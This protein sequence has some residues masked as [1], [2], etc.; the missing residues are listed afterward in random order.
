VLTLGEVHTG[1]LLTSSAVTNDTASTLLAV[2]PGGAVRSRRRPVR[3]ACSP[4]VLTGVDCPARAPG[5]RAARV[6]GTATSRVSLTDGHILQVGTHASLVRDPGGRRRPWAHYLAQ[7]GILEVIGAF[8][9]DTLADGFLGE[10]A[11]GGDTALDLGAVSTR[12]L[13]TVQR[14][15]LLDHRPPFHSRRTRLRWAAITPD[16][17]D[18]ERELIFRLATDG[19]R[20]VRLTTADVEPRLLADFCADIALHDWLLSTLLE[21]VDRAIAVPRPPTEVVARLRPAIDHLVHTWMPA[22]HAERS[23]AAI[24]QEFDTRWGFSL[25]WQK[26]VERIRDQLSVGIMEALQL[27]RSENA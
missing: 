13:A 1:L 18:P 27:R 14:S 22:A 11:A 6:V 23:L 3:Y 26:T 25:Q 16:A 9:P 4:D 24:W 5:G 19:L 12:T 21:L 7:P 15:R 2:V 20:T 8:T 10:G 17:P